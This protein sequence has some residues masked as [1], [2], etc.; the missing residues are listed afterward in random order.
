MMK[1][2]AAL[3]GGMRQRVA[4]GRTLMEDRPIVLMDEPFSALDALTRIELQALAAEKLGGRTVLLVTH[5]ALEAVRLAE[6]IFVMTGK[7]ARL[8]GLEPP[9]GLPPRSPEDPEL[10][11]AQAAVLHEL[12]L[13]ETAA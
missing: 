8:R 1:R 9:P 7:P 3:S 13:R 12:M 4:L 6:H 2:P 11:E 10:L 5:D